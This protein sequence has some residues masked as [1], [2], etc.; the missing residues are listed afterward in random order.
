MKFASPP[1]KMVDP[2]EHLVEFYGTDY[3]AGARNVSSYLADGLKQGEAVLVVATPECKAA[4]CRQLH[5]FGFN[6]KSGEFNKRV[7]FRDAARMLSKLL[8][9]GDPDWELFKF[10]LE[11]E[12]QRLRS[13]TQC[14]DFR[15]Y[16]E[17][18]GLLWTAQQFAAAIRLEE[19]WNRLLQSHKFK[20]FCGYPI[21]IFNGD[22]SHSH[23]ASVLCAHTHLLPI[24]EKGPLKEALAEAANQVPGKRE[25]Y[26]G[27]LEESRFEG[28]FE[29]LDRCGLPGAEKPLAMIG[30]ASPPAAQYDLRSRD[31]SKTGASYSDRK[32]A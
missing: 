31:A 29:G 15:V 25:I 1:S 11:D 20:L 26:F 27:D 6:P 14:R 12:V 2:E 22:F 21:D 13:T 30:R 32:T 10:I 9:K 24:G 18:V 7:V 5:Y 16:G 8:V 4:I 23:V 17:M 28:R 3:A 19:H